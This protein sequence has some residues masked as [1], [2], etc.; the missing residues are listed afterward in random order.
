MIEDATCPGCGLLCD[1][2]T[3]VVE[4]GRI[5]ETRGGCDRGQVWFEGRDDHSGGPTILGRSASLDDA[6]GR[7]A[8]LLASAKAP[9][10]WGLAGSSIEAQRVAVSIADRI[11]A[12]VGI[13]GA[14][15]AGLRAFQRVGEVSATFGEVKDRADLIVYDAVDS[16]P[17]PERFRERF[18]DEA[19]GRFVPE[20]RTGRTIVW[21]GCSD[22]P[23]ARSS[24][25]ALKVPKDRQVAFYAVVRALVNGI[26]FE[27]EPVLRSTGL[28]LASL[29]EF[30]ERLKRAKYGALVLGRSADSSAESEAKLTLVRDLNAHTRFVAIHVGGLANGSGAKAVLTWQ[31]GAAGDIDFGGG[32]PAH[33]PRDGVRERLQRG[34][35][36]LA[37]IVSNGDWPGDATPTIPCILIHDDHDP[38]PIAG[39]V[40]VTFPTAR[41]GIDEGGTVTR[42][43]GVML[44]LRPPFLGRKTTQ[45]EVLLGIEARLKD[46]SR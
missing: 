9:A 39:L 28:P 31:A 26:A 18:A 40:E 23:H 34:E 41:L 38:S 45:V 7:A 24:D 1:D 20:G 4:G 13:E 32:Y 17:I 6:L 8:E 46:R 37:L 30:A 5:V 10:V 2:L 43:D 36:D 16:S 27:Q 22:D 42:T 44:P 12:V 14:D 33:C 15:P 11:G 19:V 25:F 21:L 3:L 35:I 29:V